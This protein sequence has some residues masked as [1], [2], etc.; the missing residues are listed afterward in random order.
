MYTIKFAD[1][2]ELKNISMNGNNFISQE[3]LT[4]EYFTPEKLS[5]V[6]IM[7]DDDEGMSSMCGTFENA[8]LMFCKQYKNYPGFDDG[9]YFVL[10]V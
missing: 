3:E 10:K 8:K 9:Y 1:G 2:S 7:A 5:Q 4:A 6:T